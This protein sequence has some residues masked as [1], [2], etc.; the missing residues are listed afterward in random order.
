VGSGLYKNKCYATS[1]QILEAPQILQHL[2]IH[3]I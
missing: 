2:L 3:R 1:E